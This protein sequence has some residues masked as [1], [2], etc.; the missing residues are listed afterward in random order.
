MRD[1][2][3][4]LFPLLQS[5]R[6]IIAQLE[7]VKA[8]ALAL[9][10][11][12]SA[13]NAILGLFGVEGRRSI[14]AMGRYVGASGLASRT[15]ALKLTFG[16]WHSDVLQRLRRISAIR[17]KNK[18]SEN[19]AALAKR[20][21]KAKSYN[22]LDTQI[23]RSVGELEAILEEDLVYNEEIPMI[24]RT[25]EDKRLLDLS[26]LPL[27]EKTQAL[28]DRHQLSSALSAHPRVSQMLEGALDAYS[29]GGK[30]SNRQALASC[31]S[32]LE[33]LVTEITGQT[34][35]RLGLANVGEGVRKKLVSDSYA[36]LSGYGSHPGGL[37]TKRDAAYGIRMTIAA[38]LWLVEHRS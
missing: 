26:Q 9:S 14:L 7:A 3:Q 2:K 31:R 20:F 28:A 27:V 5:G 16:Q 30:D 37:T 12:L 34:N 23:A 18:P 33:L 21:A 22:R 1:P 25:R 11:K 15:T 24:L 4:D 13:G 36:F 19:S 10:P 8:D 32:A 17:S 29:L 38:C 35:W 6:A